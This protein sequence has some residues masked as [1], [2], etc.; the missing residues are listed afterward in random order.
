[1]MPY[2]PTDSL[3]RKS[4]DQTAVLVAVRG[5]QTYYDVRRG[6]ALTGPEGGNGW[7]DDPTGPHAYL[8]ERAAPDSV[9]AVIEALMMHAPV[10]PSAERQ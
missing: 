9:A 6:R 1:S 10:E 3:G 4:W 5:P 8:I 2:T 7:R